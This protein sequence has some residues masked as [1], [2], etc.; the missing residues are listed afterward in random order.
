[1]PPPKLLVQV[2]PSPMQR[3]ARQQPPPPHFWS[4]Q[5]TWPGLPHT[6]Q[7]FPSQT[8]PARQLLAAAPGQQDSPGPPQAT[9][10]PPAPPPTEVVVQR[11]PGSL[12]ELPQQLCPLPPHPEH[13]PA[14]QVPPPLGPV[15]PQAEPFG[16]QT[17]L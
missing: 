6:T 14:M 11:V 12:Q 10:V 5:Q 17:L 4:G 15:G 9:H 2:W 1:L 3:P 8:V 16:T 13:L 7:M